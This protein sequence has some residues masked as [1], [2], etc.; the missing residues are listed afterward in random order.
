MKFLDRFKRKNSNPTD[1]AAPSAPPD[2]QDEP[3]PAESSQVED[4]DELRLELGDFLHRIP[5]HLLHPGAH[6]L[7][8]EIYFS[9]A[10]LSQRIARGETTVD[11]VTVYK[12]VPQIFRTEV[13]ATDNLQVR[14]PW[15]RLAALVKP[16]TPSGV[17][18]TDPSPAHLLDEL[19]ARMP[20]RASAA[21]AQTSSSD[22]E[23]LSEHLRKTTQE[24]DAALQD[25]AR[26]QREI[27]E[28]RDRSPLAAITAER[29]AL[30]QQKA[31]LS[32]QMADLSRRGQGSALLSSSAA[33]QQ[34]QVEEFQRRIALMES[35]QRDTALELS[36]EKEAR[37]KAEKLLTA[38]DK[39]QEQSANYMITARAEIRREVECSM[40]AREIE[41]RRVQKDLQDQLAT[42]GELY[43]KAS[44][45]LDET[46]ALLAETQQA[47]IPGPDPSQTE[48]VE[49]LEAEIGTYRERVDALTRE[50]DQALEDA[51]NIQSDP[52]A[53]EVEAACAKL[54]AEVQRLKREQVS[55]AADMASATAKYEGIFADFEKEHTSVVQAKEDLTQRLAESE[56]AR[57]ILEKEHAKAGASGVS[58]LGDPAL[59]A[60]LAS[61][62]ER[63]A[64]LEKEL[65]AALAMSTEKP[66]GLTPERARLLAQRE[67]D[68]RTAL[69]RE[70]ARVQA[71]RDNLVSERDQLLLRAAE[72]GQK[73]KPASSDQPTQGELLPANV[74]EVSEVLPPES[75]KSIR[76]PRARPATVR[77]PKI[78]NS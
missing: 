20:E 55:L 74:I 35:S 52:R 24:R 70:L 8:T 41:T 12:Q 50:R 13:R 30:L 62:R 68:D 66:E 61:T 34:R 67:Q 25:V 77:P 29:D 51:K 23:V 78:R 26:L 16:A 72:G 60:E 53:A 65:A 4:P 39:R 44:L 32:R 54:E 10:D 17:E 5:A 31:H 49:Q 76:I 28:L 14:F 9:I 7:K 19:K 18:P 58:L 2:A 6:D 48:K 59:Q 1:S 69:Q 75:E 57:R 45:D 11:L 38:A 47:G 36:R 43:R 21:I 63:L 27:E 73:R 56:R 40:K 15:Q 64:T 71:E 3:T 37:A 46:R 22:S 33:T 42:L